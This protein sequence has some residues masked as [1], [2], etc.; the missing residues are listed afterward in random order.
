M[1]GIQLEEHIR[2]DLKS[3]V[4]KPQIR[5]PGEVSSGE[6]APG[7]LSLRLIVAPVN[8]RPGYRPVNCR[9]LTVAR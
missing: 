4:R 3:P 2:Q 8:C 1:D 9:R 6:M 7:Y 5:P